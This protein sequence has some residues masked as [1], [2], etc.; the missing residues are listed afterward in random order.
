VG[1]ERGRQLLARVARQRGGDKTRAWCT[2]EEQR[3][4]G[5]DGPV[6]TILFLFIQNF[7][8]GFK[9]EIVKR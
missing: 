6:H 4:Y 2:A 7:P 8:K 5:W 3:G 9:F 1:L